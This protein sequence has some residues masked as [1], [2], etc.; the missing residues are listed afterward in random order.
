M[1]FQRN[2]TIRLRSLPRPAAPALLVS[3]VLLAM[4]GC[5]TV[6]PDY[7]GA[8]PVAAEALKAPR[9]VRD[10]AG[11]GNAS[12]APGTAL[13]T[14][15][16]QATAP[17]SAPSGKPVAAPTAAWWLSLNDPQLNALIDQAL[18]NSP[19]LQAAQARLRQS[20]AALRQQE[21]QRMPKGSASAL[22]AGVWQAP[23]TRSEST[24]H[25]YSVG[26]DATWE[27]DL[28]GGTRRAT[29]AA[30]AQAESV[31]AD[32]ADA[33]VSLAAEV[34]QAYASLRAQQQRQDLLRATATADAQTLDLTRQRQSRGV[35]AADDV[36]QRLLQGESTQASLADVAA[37]I[38]MSL[39]QLAVL[40]GQAPG[41]L[42]APLASSSG[43]LPALPDTVAIGDPSGLLQRRPDIRAAERRLAA[44][45]ARIG[46]KEAG[47]FPKL[48]LL[49]D[50]GMAGTDLGHL[51]TSKSLALVGVPY[52][53]WNVLDFGRTQA[54]VRQAE[55]GRDEAVAQYHAT[56]LSALQDANTALSRYGQQRQAL[57]HLLAQQASAERSLALAQQRRQAGAGS[58]LD[59]LDAQRNQVTAALRTLDG[60]AALV[61]DFVSLQKSLGL[62]WGVGGT[63]TPPSDAVSKD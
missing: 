20:R 36:E 56:V 34:A 30:T 38:S 40:T 22:G 29:E 27:A 24:L 46:Q 57:M 59:L 32:L 43:H 39:D 15:S 47:Y 37:Q 41:A 35:S 18:A 31:Q 52:L 48:T 28:F 42:D 1:L 55:A 58:Q 53:S 13:A 63:G 2:P 12:N 9:F 54:E 51:L 6:G 11:A 19:T 26:F 16:N 21:A 17:S 23:G 62:G 50:I 5:T 14:S 60:E 25:L 49:G 7:R 3:A 33:Q 44:S 8:P 10:G 4:A 45:Q 61:K